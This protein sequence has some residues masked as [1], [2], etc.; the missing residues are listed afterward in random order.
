MDPF[1]C[2]PAVL[3]KYIRR[4]F[5]SGL[6]YSTINLHRSSISKFHSGVGETIGGHSLVNQAMKA[7]F[8][9]RPLLPKY[10]ATYDITRVFAY[11]QSL[12]E[13]SELSLKQL[14]LKCAF[15]VTVS[16]VSRVNSLSSLGPTLLVYRVR[17]FPYTM[18]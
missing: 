14:T 15:L 16:T 7:V 18:F 9:Q 4:M 12:P 3:V 8:R 11:I 6:S 17:Y 5:E 2:S 10:V 1:N 13:N